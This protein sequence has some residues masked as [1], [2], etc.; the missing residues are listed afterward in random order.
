MSTPAQET[1]QQPQAQK[2]AGAARSAFRTIIDQVGGVTNYALSVLWLFLAWAGWAIA[3]GGLAATQHIENKQG[4]SYDWTINANYPKLQSGR[5]YRFDWFTWSF[6][7]VVLAIVSVALLSIVIRQSRAMLMGYLAVASV[8]QILSADR[9]YNVSHFFK[10]KYYS[11]TRCTFA[12][13]VIAATADLALIYMLGLE[14]YPPP[15]GYAV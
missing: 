12:G 15:P 8:L 11:R 3:L 2:A 14:P 9:F 13:Y 1:F 6:Q 7:L 10:G 4:L 5:V